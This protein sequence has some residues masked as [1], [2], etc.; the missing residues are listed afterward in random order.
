[1]GKGR[2]QVGIRVFKFRLDFLFGFQKIGCR[3]PIVFGNPRSQIVDA[4]VNS[5]A[6]HGRSPRRLLVFDKVDRKVYGVEGAYVGRLH[7]ILGVIEYA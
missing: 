7:R 1:M 4:L 2:P 3:R 6:E 5:V